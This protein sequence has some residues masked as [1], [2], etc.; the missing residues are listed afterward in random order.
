MLID[1]KCDLNKCDI[2]DNSIYHKLLKYQRG[3]II[4]YVLSFVEKDFVNNK[5]KSFIHNLFAYHSKKNYKKMS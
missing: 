5:G 2:E 1:S 4:K 3:H